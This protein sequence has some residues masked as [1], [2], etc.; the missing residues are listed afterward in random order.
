MLS[1]QCS[2]DTNSLQVVY[3][4]TDKWVQSI[5]SK[6]QSKA[7]G[8]SSAMSLVVS[9]KSGYYQSESPTLTT[10]WRRGCLD[11]RRFKC[12]LSFFPKSSCRPAATTLLLKVKTSRFFQLFVSHPRP[13]FSVAIQHWWT[14]EG[15]RSSGEEKIYRN[16][17]ISTNKPSCKFTSHSATLLCHCCAIKTLKKRW[18]FTAALL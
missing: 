5:R 2:K 15:R 16:P 14:S 10:S 13:F 11:N 18:D 6:I 9:Q 3:P 4:G 12:I 8:A 1:L 7:M 17:F